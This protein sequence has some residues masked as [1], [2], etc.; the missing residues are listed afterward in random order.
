[1]PHFGSLID[2][3]TR[4]TPT[5]RVHILEKRLKRHEEQALHKYYE[6]DYKLRSDTRLEALLSI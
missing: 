6:L 4:Q 3:H 2:S 1:M 5:R